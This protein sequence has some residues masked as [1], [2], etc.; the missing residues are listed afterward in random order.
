M[1]S[2]NKEFKGYKQTQKTEAKIEK[3]K[4]YRLNGLY[5]IG[6]YEAELFRRSGYKVEEIR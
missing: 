1:R 3:Q 5:I 6:E 2:K 4:A